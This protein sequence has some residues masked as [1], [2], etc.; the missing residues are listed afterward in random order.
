M[1]ISALFAEQ[2]FAMPLTRVQQLLIPNKKRVRWL[3]RLSFFSLLIIFSTLNM[4]FARDANGQDM[5]RI[6][7]KFEAKN[8]SLVESL[9][10]IQRRTPFTFAYNKKDL[11]GVETTNLPEEERSVKETLDLLFQ[12]TRLQY[13]QVGGNIVISV[14][15]VKTTAPPAEP[16]PQAYY[17]GAAPKKDITGTVRNEKG[18]PMAGVSVTL[19]NTKNGTTTDE[20]GRFR[21]SVDDGKV[22]LEFSYIG[23]ESQSREITGDGAVDIVLKE[24]SGGLN[25]VVVVG[26]GTQKKTDVTAAV[27]SIKSENFVKGSVSDAGQLIRGKVAGLAVITP[28]ANPTSVSQ[29]NLRGIATIGANSSPLILID[30]VPGT[31]TTVAPED[32][33]SIDILKDGSAAAIYGTRGTNGVILIT[34]KK[35]NGATPTTIDL[36]TYFTVQKITKK[37][38][39]MSPDQ[40]REL[41]AQGKP[42]ATDYGANTN[43]LDEVTQTPFS[44]VYNINLKSG[45]KT[46]N[47]N[48]NLNYRKLNGLI[49]RTDNIVLYPRIEVNHNMFDGKLKFNANLGGY[50]QQYFSGSDG[51]SY[52]PEVYKNALHYNPTDP[53]KDADGNWTEHPDKTDYANPVSLLQEA[54]GINRLNNFRTI[55]TLT[56][57]PISEL[58]IRLMGSRDV[59]NAT[60]GYYETKKNYSTIHDGKNGYASRGTTRNQENLLELTAT[61]NKRFGDHNVTGLLGYSWRQYD[62][63][64]YYMQNWDFP[65]DDF[66]YNNMGAGLALKRGEAVQNSYQSRNKLIGYFARL[67][68]SFKEKYL[69][70]ASVRREGSSKF[71]ANYKY[72]N[73]P[74]VSAGWNIQKEAF[75]QNVTAVSTLKLRGGFGITGT[76]P[77]DPYT[78][79]NRINFNTYVLVN[80]TWI[81][82]TN[83]ATNAN[84]DLRWERKKETN[85]GLDFGFLKN[86]ITGSVDWYNRT[87]KDLI[88][89]YPVATPP[90][91]YNTIRANAASMQNKGIEVQVNAVPFETKTFSW[92]TT[93][94]YS[95]NK[96]KLL[97]LSDKNFQLASGYFDAGNTGEP[98]Q[99]SISR[100]QIGQP[101][102]NFWGFKSVDVDDNGRWI[103]EGKDGKPKPI[104][105]QQADDKQIIGNGLPKHY[106]AFNNTFTYKNFDLNITMR[107]AFGFQIL[108]TMRMF[109]EVPVMLTRGNLLTTAYDKVYG[110]HVLADN[111]E[112][113]YLSYYIEDGDYWKIDNVTIGYNLSIKNSKYIKRVRIYASGSNLKT[114]TG[115]K[116]IDPEVNIIGMSPGVDVRTRYPAT[117]SYTL[118]AF[119]TF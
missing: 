24:I 69:L 13:E 79:L 4:L 17:Q 11:T 45:N 34:T 42:G 62:Y 81:Q 14:K 8:E 80:G 113:Q 54:D 18:A 26:Y 74:A 85:I 86:R 63:E 95:T 29:I 39:F 97:S 56:Y 35:A 114:F 92:T 112:L 49:K 28:D 44:Q 75:F 61:Y 117:S 16:A 6:K 23:F 71:G 93:V 84:P 37:L 65:T 111:Q 60:R 118:G 107:G 58:N 41:V 91:L 1:N 43:W 89:D 82:V 57:Q 50:Q 90:Y 22:T 59:T 101:I 103:I 53:V 38:N 116:G 46:T 88:F 9:K 96:N 12:D 98:I 67:N 21:L 30:N 99:Q 68:Y 78:S 40:Y 15:A 108:N 76:E 66:T 104:A 48:V 87:T 31:L 77:N 51:G 27:A 10:K 20:N 36:N 102:G 70:T 2:G 72:G 119:F 83:L 100:V 109:H 106:L 52:R 3:M 105:Q 64:D 32:I 25:E 94:N 73:F 33:E 47:Y 115:Y 55:G 19:Q 5:S 110:K 7:I